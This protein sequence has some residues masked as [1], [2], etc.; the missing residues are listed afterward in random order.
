MKFL[1]ALLF[2]LCSFCLFAQDSLK[3]E[4]L[5]SVFKVGQEKRIEIRNEICNFGIT[6]GK[7][8]VIFDSIYHFLNSNKRV[9]ISIIQH[10]D[11]RGSTAANQ[12]L[13]EARAKAV[14]TELVRK[15][16]TADRVEAIGKGE[17][18]PIHPEKEINQYKESN[19][20]KF[21]QLH[22][23]NRRTI[24]RITKV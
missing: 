21:E 3:F 19:P 13:S 12:K 4:F 17:S 2:S 23:I 20:D 5:D 24:I 22:Q 1:V 18:E 8:Q 15:G 7:K 16:I 6:D 9:S 14:K 11:T 10:T